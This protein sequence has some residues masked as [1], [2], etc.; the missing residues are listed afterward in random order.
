MNEIL[1]WY[2]DVLKNFN[3]RSLA[4]KID[5]EDL[6]ESEKIEYLKNFNPSLLYEH[7]HVLIYIGSK[8]DGVYAGSSYSF[9]VFFLS[10]C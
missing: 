2:N 1:N 3:E 10:C 9:G 4:K 6:R 5:V 8:D 7:G